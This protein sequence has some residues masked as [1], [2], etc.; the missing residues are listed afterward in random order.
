MAP[1]AFDADIDKRHRAP[2]QV[3]VCD[4][5]FFVDRRP[6]RGYSGLAGDSRW[7]SAALRPLEV[8]AQAKGVAARPAVS[9]GS[10]FVFLNEVLNDG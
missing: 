4:A 6:A 1:S 7:S 10:L 5:Q 3:E 2:D 8:P 9:G